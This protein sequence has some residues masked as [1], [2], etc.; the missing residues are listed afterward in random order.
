[1][2]N[3][4]VHTPF[5]PNEQEYLQD[6]LPADFKVYFGNL[7][8]N[9]AER[10]G[11]FLASEVAFGNVEADWLMQST[12]LRW[13]QLHSAGFNEY[14]NLAWHDAPLNHLTLTNLKS[15]FGQPV[16]ETAL[17]G[18]LALYRK[19]FELSLLQPQKH[20]VGSAMRPSMQL[21]YRRKVLVLGK[22]DIAESLHRLLK[23]FECEVHLT[24]RTTEADR[25]EYLLRRADVVVS[26]LPENPQT[27]GYLDARRLSL[28]Q[29]SAIFVNVGRGTTV[30]E[31]A[32]YELLFSRKIAGAVLD[33]TLHEP[34]PAAHPFWSMPQVLLTQH[35]AGGYDRENQDK[36]DYFL[37]N[38]QLYVS[39]QTLKGVVQI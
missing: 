16:A 22:G 10:K 1:M 25:L 19:V 32:L 6:R 15:F 20:W 35:T 11:A 14:E 28:L 5:R 24:G 4:Y 17:A 3:L 38:L 21:L 29:P 26:T 34:L 13:L 23:G 18:I 39:R 31:A 30:D 12:C 8:S 27:I 7:L 33:V 2:P 37:Q 36:I 9:D